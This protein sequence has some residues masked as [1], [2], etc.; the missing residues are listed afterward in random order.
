MRSVRV[1]VGPGYSAALNSL[2]LEMS[3]LEAVIWVL[4]L[5]I[6]DIKLINVLPH[7]WKFMISADKL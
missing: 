5:Q 7:D 1:T 4:Y 2:S 3:K 6:C